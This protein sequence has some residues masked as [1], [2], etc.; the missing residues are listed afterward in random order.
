M[1][2]NEN[3]F[4]GSIGG[5]NLEYQAIATAREIIQENRGEARA[6]A[7]P[8]NSGPAVLSSRRLWPALLLQVLCG[9]SIAL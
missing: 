6:T 9:A 5:G 7:S 8:A 4:R 1:V 3:E 2:V